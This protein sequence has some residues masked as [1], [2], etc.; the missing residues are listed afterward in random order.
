[1]SGLEHAEGGYLVLETVGGGGSMMLIS[2][3]ERSPSDSRRRR[4]TAHRP[5]GNRPT[6][7]VC[8]AAFCVLVLAC[9]PLSSAGA[10]T[11]SNNSTASNPQ[12]PSGTSL[13]NR[14]YSPMYGGN[15]LEIFTTEPTLTPITT[16]GGLNTPGELVTTGD[17]RDLYIND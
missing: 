6:R 15:S 8:S 1:M 12:C 3:P 17:G 2:R 10:V 11:P 14:A 5:P 4:R 13:A 16:V 9:L 7:R